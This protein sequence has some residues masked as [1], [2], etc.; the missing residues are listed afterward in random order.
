MS[1]SVPSGPNG[2]HRIA[3]VEYETFGQGPSTM[4]RRLSTLLLGALLVAALAP[5]AATEDR[6]E[7]PEPSASIQDVDARTKKNVV[8]AAREYLDPEIEFLW[9]PKKEL[10]AQ[11]DELRGMGMKPLRDIPLLRS[12]VYEGRHFKPRFEDNKWRSLNDVQEWKKTKGIY[13]NLKSELF[14]FS[15]AEPRSYPTENALDRKREEIYPGLFVFHEE[16]DT[17]DRRRGAEEHPGAAALERLYPKREFSDLYERW[18]VMAPVAP[19]AQFLDD[20][21]RL[22]TRFATTVLRE[23]WQRYHL[24]FDRI[25]VDGRL[26][27]ATMA[28]STPFLFA[29]LILRGGEI[30]EGMVTNLSTIPIYVVGKPEL[31]KQLDAAGHPDVIV[32]DADGILPWLAERKRTTPKSFSWRVLSDQHLWANWLLVGGAQ[33]GPETRI[34]VEVLDTEEHPNTIKVDARGV[35][36]VSMFLSDEIVDF[37]RDVNLLVN[38][39]KTELGKLERDVSQTFENKATNVRETMYFG[40]L[41]PVFIPEVR[42]PPPPAAESTPTEA[43]VEEEVVGTPE[44]ESKAQKFWDKAVEAEEAGEADKARQLYQLVVDVGPTSFRAKALAKLAE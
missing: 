12:I 7:T 29:G 17:I 40:W 22:L 42:I 5:F 34:D 43:P 18:F 13:Y 10:N 1:P 2:T 14:R 37:D 28:S 39:E 19:R 33:F 36:Q 27:A 44:D 4:T 16:E 3:S 32:G 23:F 35:E 24:D 26:E 20:N 8:K 31:K 21:G 25:V 38:G 9:M 6:P 30:P 15:F 41:Y 11:F